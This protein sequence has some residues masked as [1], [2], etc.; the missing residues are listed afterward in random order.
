MTA[1]RT[2]PPRDAPQLGLPHDDNREGRQPYG[3]EV[4]DYQSGV[5][6]PPDE[7][8]LRENNRRGTKAPTKK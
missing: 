3:K 7:Q 2:P 1:K 4:D 5:A 6:S 8:S